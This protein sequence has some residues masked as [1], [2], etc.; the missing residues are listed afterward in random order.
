MHT[1]TVDNYRRV[2]LTDA[3]PRQ[4]Y[5][6]ENEADGRVVLTPVKKAAAEPFPDDYHFELS[7]AENRELAVLAK[8]SSLQ[9]PE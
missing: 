5:A 9:V 1:V 3:K 8:S 6:V 2:R 7:D 4:V